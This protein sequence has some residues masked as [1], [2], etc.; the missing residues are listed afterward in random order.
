MIQYID[1]NTSI[2][3]ENISLGIRYVKYI[4]IRFVANRVVNCA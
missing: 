2:P 3:N 1:F 4:L